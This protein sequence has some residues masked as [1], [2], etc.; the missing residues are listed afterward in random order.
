MQS[1]FKPCPASIEKENVCLLCLQSH[2]F[3]RFTLLVDSPGVKTVL[4]DGLW[5]WR[6]RMSWLGRSLRR[7]GC[8][9]V[10]IFSYDASGL[11]PLES[12]ADEFARRYSGQGPI[13]VVAHSMGG[14]V[15]R[16][17]L[18]MHP[19]IR[20]EKSVFV[21]S[22]HAG[23]VWAHA[24]PL[25]GI[26]QLR[27]GSELLQSLAGQSWDIRTMVIWCPGDLMVFPGSSA[28][29]PVAE[30]QLRCDIPFHNWP[31]FSPNFH[32]KIAGFLMD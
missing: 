21:N 18:W 4:V 27:P 19:A 30:I 9:E 28:C 32:K 11:Q 10:E 3:A 7:L 16:T 26:R 13:Q 17:A 25:P 20:L 14:I 12:A 5:G 8:G 6:P 22:P 2:I 1:G 23:S 15:I 31:L 24:L 29:W